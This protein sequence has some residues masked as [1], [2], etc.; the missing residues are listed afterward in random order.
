MKKLLLILCLL[1]AAKTAIGA[2]RFGRVILKVKDQ[3]NYQFTKLDDADYP[4]LSNDHYSVTCLV[5]RGTERYYVEV[6]ISNKTTG[7]VGPRWISS[8]SISPGIRFL[9]RT[10]WPRPERQ[11]RLPAFG[12]CQLRHRMLLPRP[13]RASMRPLPHTETKLRL[14][15]LRQPRQTIRGKQVRT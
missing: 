1:F 10:R 5:Y 9:E 2:D 4:G 12:L 15:V 11:L 3:K 7:P 14:P 13:T 8:R 6:S